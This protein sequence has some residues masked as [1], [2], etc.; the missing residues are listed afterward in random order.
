[1]TSPCTEPSDDPPAV[2]DALRRVRTLTAMTRLQEL[3]GA[4]DAWGQEQMAV[5]VEDVRLVLDEV[6][7]LRALAHPLSNPNQDQIAP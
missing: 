1:M 4:V 5:T 6:R 2:R 3:A 7:R